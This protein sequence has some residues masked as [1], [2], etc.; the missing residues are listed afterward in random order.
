MRR[1]CLATATAATATGGC[2][3]W[4]QVIFVC[5]SHFA[6]K[7]QIIVSAKQKIK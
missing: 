6:A 3:Q 7:L 1:Y 2:C 5:V 4:D